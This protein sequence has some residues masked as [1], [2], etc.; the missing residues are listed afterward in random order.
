VINF[1]FLLYTDKDILPL[2]LS[3]PTSTNPY[4]SIFRFSWNFFLSLKKISL[5]Y[6][7]QQKEN[8][9]NVSNILGS[10]TR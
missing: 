10:H 6:H 1:L 2:Y 7:S 9:Q 5:G 8:Y 3:M 4:L